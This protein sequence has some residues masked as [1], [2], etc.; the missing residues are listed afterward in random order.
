MSLPTSDSDFTR[1]IQLFLIRSRFRKLDLNILRHHP[2]YFFP[3]ET[4]MYAHYLYTQISENTRYR[5]TRYHHTQV[6]NK[7]STTKF[8]YT[9]YTRVHKCFNEFWKKNW[10]AE[11]KRSTQNLPLNKLNRIKKNWY[12]ERKRLTKHE[13]LNKNKANKIL[14]AWLS[15]FLRKC[16]VAKAQ[17]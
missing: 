1:W 7:L 17:K 11:K 10:V 12:V 5:C 8:S 4:R 2:N 15:S 14:G 13:F 6:E 3:W 9:R 16:K